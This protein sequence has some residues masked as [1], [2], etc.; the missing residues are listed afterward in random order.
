MPERW[1]RELS[2]LRHAP[3]MPEAIWDRVVAG[4]RRAAPAPARSRALT[5][6]VALG[7]FAATAVL[8]VWAFG[9][10][11]N[12]AGPASGSPVLDVP[13]VGQT[14]PELLSD[15]HPVFVV[16][17]EDGAIGVVDAV[18]THVPFGIRKLVGWCP[19]SRTFDDPFHGSKWN[20]LGDYLLGPAPT[21][22]ITYESTPIPGDPRRVRVGEPI[23]TQPRGDDHGVTPQGSFCETT[24]EM[25]LPKLPSQVA[26][27][28]A[29]VVAAAPDGWVA[30]KA[31][32]LMVAGEGSRLCAD[33]GTDGSCTEAAAVAGV[34]AEG[35]LA[36]AGETSVTLGGT[37]IARVESG[38]LVDL[39]RVP[40]AH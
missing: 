12:R 36:S 15:G 6:A 32:L 10:G 14:A 28:P 11:R 23:P 38:A 30:V 37:W 39:T 7:A 21:G 33:V 19:S 4:E 27:S 26:D 13:P 5:A 1:Q 31:V 9:P 16:H 29:S 18:S 2:K 8:L 22:L 25:V 3:E 40:E 24:A 20:E 35:L 17:R 34:D